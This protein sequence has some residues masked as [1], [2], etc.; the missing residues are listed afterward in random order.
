MKVDETEDLYAINGLCA[1]NA[2][3]FKAK[4]KS[5]ITMAFIMPLFAYKESRSLKGVCQWGCF[6]LY[7]VDF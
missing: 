2:L 5:R 4:S 6:V 1:N 7:L 3:S